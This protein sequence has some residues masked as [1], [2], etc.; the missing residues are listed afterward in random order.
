MAYNDDGE[1]GMRRAAVLGESFL[2][3]FTM[4]GFLRRLR[5]PGEAVRLLEPPLERNAWPSKVFEMG[6]GQDAEV[7]LSGDL[8]RVPEPALRKMMS[9]LESESEYRKRHTSVTVQA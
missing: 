3:G 4:A 5:R 7:A 2:D 1:M 8:H 6:A 9:L